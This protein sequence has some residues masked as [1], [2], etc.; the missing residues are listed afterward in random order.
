LNCCSE[1]PYM[2]STG[3]VCLTD[4]QRNFIQTRGFNKMNGDI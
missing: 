2:T 4:N 1:S 3:C